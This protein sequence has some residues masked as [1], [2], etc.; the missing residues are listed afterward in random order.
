M[1]TAVIT[2]APGMTLSVTGVYQQATNPRVVPRSASGAYVFRSDTINTDYTFSITAGE[3]SIAATPY[4]IE[5][6]KGHV[7]APAVSVEPVMPV[8]SELC[9][10]GQYY[11]SSDEESL[12]YHLAEIID[13][14]D[15]PNDVECRDCP[16]GTFSTTGSATACLECPEYTLPNAE[17]T[18]CVPVAVRCSATAAQAS[19]I[20]GLSGLLVPAWLAVA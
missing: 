20:L 18:A 8:P 1:Y 2:P 10:P 4:T 17:H 13:T 14:G 3:G 16:A 19:W 5:I 11:G 9:E 15:E 12:A 6:L 7:L